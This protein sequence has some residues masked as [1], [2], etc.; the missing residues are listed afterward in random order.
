MPEKY[1]LNFN[2]TRRQWLLSQTDS[3]AFL[4]RSPLL[5]SDTALTFALNRIT[6]RGCETQL[7]EP[8]V[9]Q[10]THD[11]NESNELSDITT[12]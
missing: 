11:Q 4:S 9:F 2:G 8:E 12:T 3:V 7:S 5:N 10:S 1:S 6:Q